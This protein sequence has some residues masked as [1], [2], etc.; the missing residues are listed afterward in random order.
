MTDRIKSITTQYDFI[1][2]TTMFLV[3]FAHVCWMY[4]GD[5]VITPIV[6]STLLS[7]LAKII[8]TFHMPLYMCTTGMVYGYC[9]DDM[10]KYSDT[11]KFVRSKF[12]RLIVPYL[13]IGCFWVAPIMVFFHF[14]E[15]NY[16]EYIVKGIFFAENPRH[17]WFLISL[18]IIFIICA[19]F[20]KLRFKINPFFGII[21]AFFCAC[22]SDHLPHYFKLRY[23]CY[24]FVIF[25]LGMLLNRYRRRYE[26]ASGRVKICIN[27]ICIFLI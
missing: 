14:T 7:S 11:A 8:Y 6:P 18:F 9:I 13:F 20:K 1:K 3:V 2:V 24:Y 22:F 27:L 15:S 21:F 4:T 26:Q 5:G 19:T 25:Y 16:P 10:N 12:K 17:L 23:A